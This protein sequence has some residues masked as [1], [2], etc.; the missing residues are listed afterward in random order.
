VSLDLVVLGQDPRFEG[1]GVALTRAFAAAATALEREVTVL[2]DPHPGLGRPRLTWRRV[3]ALRQ[4]A[5][6]RRLGPAARDARSLWVAASMP[7][8]GGAAPR[9]GRAYGCWVATTIRAE[10]SGRAP[11]LPRWRRRAAAASIPALERLERDVLAR[12]AAL[13][14][15]SPASR[16]DIAAAA[17]RSQDDVG[18]LRIPVDADRFAPAPDD[19]WRRALAAPVLVFVG[20][21]NDPRKNLPLLLAAFQEVRAGHPRA[22]LRLVGEPPVGPVPAGVEIVGPV[23]D[24][25]AE[26]RRASILVLPSRQEGFG[27]VAA[28]ALAAGVPVIATPCGGPEELIR[29]SRGGRVLGGFTADELAAAITDVVADPTTAGTMRDSGRAFVLENHA[30]ARFREHVAEALRKLD[31]D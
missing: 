31:A 23:A 22:Q 8:Y 9:S 13:F 18:L 28:E 5:A 30:P 6:A 3:E 12:S 4:L 26:L 20:R 25:A 24:V 10:W 7:Q 1:G 2:H 21:A 11:G 16:A 19:D 15:T 14:A 27:I 17:E 29:S